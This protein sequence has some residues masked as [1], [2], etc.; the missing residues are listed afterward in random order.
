MMMKSKTIGK[1]LHRTENDAMGRGTRLLES[2]VACHYVATEAQ[3]ST[4]PL[5]FVETFLIDQIP[6]NRP[7]ANLVN[8]HEPINTQ[9]YLS[10]LHG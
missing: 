5:M 6:N 9:C 2:Y 3:L 7:R 4:K 8:I 1:I 10:S